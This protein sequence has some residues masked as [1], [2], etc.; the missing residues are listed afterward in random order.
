[1]AGPE[2]SKLETPD[3]SRYPAP[4]IFNGGSMAIIDV[5]SAG[6][7]VLLAGIP[8]QQILI[9]S[10]FFQCSVTSTITFKS[11]TTLLSGPM[12]FVAGGGANM[13]FD[14]NIPIFSCG[15]GESFIMNVSGLL[16][17]VGGGFY[18]SQG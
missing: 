16:P 12:A 18:Y 9:Y 7:T 1:M 13:F 11:D 6:D 3:R 15:I 10:M 4:K 8:G 2:P 14:V 17:A 5:T